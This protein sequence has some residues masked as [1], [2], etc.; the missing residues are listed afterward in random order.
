MYR[1]SKVRIKGERLPKVNTIRTCYKERL[2]LSVTR[3]PI[4]C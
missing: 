1:V 3:E 2:K 4:K